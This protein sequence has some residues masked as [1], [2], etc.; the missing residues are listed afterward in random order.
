[1]KSFR[2]SEETLKHLESLQRKYPHLSQS[3]IIALL[4]YCADRD[5]TTDSD[6]FEAII[7]SPF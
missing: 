1:M 6:E 2:L 7:N 4:A 5:I 3:S